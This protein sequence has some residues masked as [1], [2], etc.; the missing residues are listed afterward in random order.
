ML[1]PTTDGVFKRYTT[2]IGSFR[3]AILRADRM[4]SLS[5]AYLNGTRPR[6]A[7]Q[8]TDG[9]EF[10]NWVINVGFAM[11]AFMCIGVQL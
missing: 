4:R 10:P 1:P 8:W 5:S 2:Q 3:P 11:S 6:E 9:F 7:I